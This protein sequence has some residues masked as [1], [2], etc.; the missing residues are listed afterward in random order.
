L[1]KK[2]WFKTEQSLTSFDVHFGCIA[3]AIGP[4]SLMFAVVFACTLQPSPKKAADSKKQN[5]GIHRLKKKR[6][7]NTRDSD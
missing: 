5:G 2:D 3:V 4:C 6:R 1:R 7:S